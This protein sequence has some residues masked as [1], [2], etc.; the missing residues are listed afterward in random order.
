MLQHDHIQQNAL[1]KIQSTTSN[2]SVRPILRIGEL[3]YSIDEY[4]IS[5]CVSPPMPSNR[6]RRLKHMVRECDYKMRPAF[7]FTFCRTDCGC[8]ARRHQR[9]PA[10]QHAVWCFNYRQAGQ[11]H[12]SVKG[13][14]RQLKSDTLIYNTGFCG[15]TERSQASYDFISRS[16]MRQHGRDRRGGRRD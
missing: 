8:D 6:T 16:L 9:H 2:N 4:D 11:T 1:R 13:T 5:V 14:D 10:A 12:A 3:R 7:L 15:A